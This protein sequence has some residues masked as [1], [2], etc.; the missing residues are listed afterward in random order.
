[1]RKLLLTTLFGVALGLGSARAEVVVSVAPPRARV[2]HHGHRPSPNHVWL[3]GYN[4][5]DG[6]AYVW[7]PGRWEV[8][9]RA[10]AVWVAPR[11]VHRHHGWVFV[12][13]HWR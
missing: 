12:E 3:N 10:R 8:R 11:W 9:P 5:W 13:G 1:M 4:R 7:E 6:R 2:E